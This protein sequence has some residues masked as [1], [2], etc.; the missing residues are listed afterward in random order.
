MIDI[1]KI[2]QTD[3]LDIIFDGRNKTYGAYEL[4]TNY[5]KRLFIAVISMILA[6]GMLLLLYSFANGNENTTAKE[7]VISDME[8]EELTEK[9]EE[10][11]LEELPKPKPQ[12]QVEIKQYTPPQIVDDEE[13]KPDD[14]P[15]EFDELKDTKIGLVDQEGIKDDNAIAPPITDDKGVIEAPV[16]KEEEDW[17]KIH[18]T[19]EIESEY[20]GGLEAWKRFLIK[21]TR[22][23]D[24]AIE[25]E[26][27]GTVLV[28]FIVDRDGVVSD[29]V[30]V[31]GPE[32]LRPE[33]VRVIKKSGQWKPAEQNGRKVKSYKRQ[34]VVFRLE[35]PGQP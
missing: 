3:V 27:Q 13:V 23:P 9:K 20:P 7:Y 28:Q 1:N 18:L 26:I 14:V 30:A 31:S 12:P 32:E 17:N 25:K 16:R 8:L 34:P 5:S 15:P 6:C 33:A 10:P 35:D 2:L 29:V 4:R 24:D 22:Y 11:P 21:T 19:V